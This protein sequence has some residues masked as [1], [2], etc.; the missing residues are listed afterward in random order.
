MKENNSILTIEQLTW[1][2]YGK[3]VWIEVLEPFS[4]EEKVSAY[5]RKQVDYTRGKAFICGYP[6]ISFGFDFS[7]Y[8]KT[9]VAY[10]EQPLLHCEDCEYFISAVD[11]CK[12]WDSVT[13]SDGYCHR[14]KLRGSEE[15]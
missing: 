12:K 7:E 6:G 13:D 9:W 1:L 15:E 4:F 10:A 11:L 8:N 5:Y 14:G 2:P 3:W